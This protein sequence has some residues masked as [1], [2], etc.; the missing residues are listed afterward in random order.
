MQLHETGQDPPTTTPRGVDFTLADSDL[1]IHCSITRAG[2]VFL[3]GHFL[4]TEDF[5]A[6]FETYQAAIERAARRKYQKG[7]DRRRRLTL[8]AH[9]LV[10]SGFELPISDETPAPAH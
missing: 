5:A 8:N 10:A 7:H 4:L 1:K 2:L 3:A 6:V 9:D